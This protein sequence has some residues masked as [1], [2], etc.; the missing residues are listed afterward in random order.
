MV[1]RK[2]S[3]MNLMFFLLEKLC[4]GWCNLLG[5]RRLKA[6]KSVCLYSWLMCVSRIIAIIKMSVKYLSSN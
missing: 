4:I 3:R 1:I 2:E 6:N 5:V